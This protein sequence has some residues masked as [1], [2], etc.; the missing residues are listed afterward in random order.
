VSVD[1]GLSD[2]QQAI[3][4]AF[5]GFFANESPP[6]VARASEP[7]GFSDQLWARS[8]TMEMAAM[9][10]PEADG[11]SGASMSD[12]IVVADALG[13]AIAPIPLIE[14]WV[15]SRLWP[16]ADVLT[17]D[18]IATIALHPAVGG[19]WAVVPAGAVADV[20]IGVDGDEV[21][22][23]RATPP[24][25]GPRNHAAM[26]LADRSTAGERTSIGPAASFDQAIAEW[27]VLTAAALVGIS[28]AAL[29]QAVD[30]VQNRVQFGRPIGSFQAVQHLLADL[31]VVI[32][33][34]HL[35]THKA[36]WALDTNQ[37][38]RVAWDDNDVTDPQALASMAFVFASDS[39]ALATDRALHVHG[40]YGFSAEYDIQLYYRR[41]RGW[42]LVYRDPS[43]ECRA[44]ADLLFG[45][46]GVN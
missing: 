25:S 29:I 35:L 44:L 16:A 24:M 36:A 37:A 11:G 38:R 26:P 1:L 9:A 34:S 22:A 45:P 40:G 12:L 19:R 4:E 41:A 8:K 3:A 23:V 5:G 39:A 6:A 15:A 20:V 30:Y 42:S 18:T 33:S 46:S 28:R 27:K 17:G 31:P 7:L 43:V 2:D 32:D 14:Q 13:Q 21:I 10:A